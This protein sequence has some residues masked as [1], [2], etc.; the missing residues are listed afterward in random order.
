LWQSANNCHF[1]DLSVGGNVG[2]GGSD[3]G[4]RAV[5]N[6]RGS[7][8]AGKDEDGENDDGVMVTMEVVVVCALEWL[9]GR[10]G[11]VMGGCEPNNT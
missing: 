1:R 6:D 5:S 11:F 7:G 10:E 4:C 2:G 3:E 8:G 9:G